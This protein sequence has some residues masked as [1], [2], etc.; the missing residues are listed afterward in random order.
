MLRST[1]SE[2]TMATLRR[3]G[4]WPP[5][6]QFAGDH[7]G[8]YGRSSVRRPHPFRDARLV[9]P[10]TL[11]LFAGGALGGLLTVFG[12]PRSEAAHFDCGHLGERC[13]GDTQGNAQCCSGICKRH[14]CR[15]HDRGICKVGQNACGTTEMNC[16]VNGT[17]SC[18]CFVTTGKAPFCGGDS[19][20]FACTRDEQCVPVKG[21]G[22][23]LRP[24]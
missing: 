8:W 21:A 12:A 24:V 10:G 7:G 1:A 20:V 18:F 23:V 16:G 17:G 15:A 4:A 6:P 2:P 22:S 3:P 5:P 14:R 19:V 13:Q 11:E 9:L